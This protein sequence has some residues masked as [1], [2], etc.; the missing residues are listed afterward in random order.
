MYLEERK[1]TPAERKAYCTVNGKW[2]YRRD[3]ELDEIERRRDKQRREFNLMM[4]QDE[5]DER[6]RDPVFKW[7]DNPLELQS[8]EKIGIFCKFLPVTEKHYWGFEMYDDVEKAY[9]SFTFKPFE[10]IQF[11]FMRA[12]EGDIVIKSFYKVASNRCQGR[13][14]IQKQ[15]KEL[16]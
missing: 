13:F 6:L 7:G 10:F 4:A 12:T 16:N 14:N 3:L 11:K 9:Y 2:D 8:E 5:A 15:T 1:M